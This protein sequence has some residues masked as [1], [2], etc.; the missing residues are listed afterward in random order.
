[1]C[2]LLKLNT[3]KIV[4]DLRLFGFLFESLVEHDLDVYINSLGG[5]LYHF[6]DNVTGEEIDAILEFADGEYGAIEIKL[7][8]NQFENAK[9]N[10]V[11]FSKKMKKAP[12][13]MR[14][15]TGYDDIISRDKETGVY[16]LPITAL[17]P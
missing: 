17:K 8:F 14:V 10:L 15:I 5:N 12:K 2:A 3:N 11:K 13:F 1:M 4:E 6:R 7:G 9:E 16:V